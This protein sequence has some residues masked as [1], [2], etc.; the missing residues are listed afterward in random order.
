GCVG[1]E[2]GCE[3]RAV[4]EW[5]CDR[6]AVLQ[7]GDEHRDAYRRVVVGVGDAVG[8]GRVCERDRE[9]LADVAVRESGGGNRWR[10]VCGE[11]LRAERALLEQRR[12]LRCRLQQRSAVRAGWGEWCVPVWQWLV[13]DPVLQQQQLLGRSDLHH[14]RAAGYDAA[15]GDVA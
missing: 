4:G 13:P 14:H 7:G 6:G 2:P 1:G 11:L 12:F 5:F 15:V 3:V 10:Y 9:W 8:D